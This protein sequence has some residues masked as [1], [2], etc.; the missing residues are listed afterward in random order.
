MSCHTINYNR[1]HYLLAVK[2][3][4]SS[5][6]NLKYFKCPCIYLL[7]YRSTVCVCVSCLGVMMLWKVLLSTLLY[8]VCCLTATIFVPRNIVS[9][10]C[11][12]CSVFISSPSTCCSVW[13]H[14]DIYQHHQHHHHRLYNVCCLKHPIGV[15]YHWYIY[16]HR[17]TTRP[18]PS[19]SCWRVVLLVSF[20][21]YLQNRTI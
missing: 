9:L 7:I 11:I 21:E 15:C 1:I 3:L 13:E 19:S 2:I 5:N 20:C 18:L 16:H 8:E 10:A 12:H 4:D 17:H 6:P 14:V